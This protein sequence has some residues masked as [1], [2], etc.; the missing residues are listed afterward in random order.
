MIEH[1]YTEVVGLMPAGCWAVFFSFYP[2]VG[3]LK[4]FGCPSWGKTSIMSTYLS[5]TS[6]KYQIGNIIG[7]KIITNPGL[8][9]CREFEANWTKKFYDVSPIELYFFFFT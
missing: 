9:G 8:I 6:F 3:F 4:M 2:S 7:E 5:Q 1:T